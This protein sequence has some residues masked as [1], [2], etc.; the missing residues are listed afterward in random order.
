MLGDNVN[1]SMM[2][3]DGASYA[4]ENPERVDPDQT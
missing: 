1:A 4:M 3:G 2:R